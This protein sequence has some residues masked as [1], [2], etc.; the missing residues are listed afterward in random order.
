MCVCVCVCV[1]DFKSR[2]SKQ[3]DL[4]SC[5]IDATQFSYPF[6]CPCVRGGSYAL[7][8][9]NEE[10]DNIIFVSGTLSIEMDGEC[11]SS[12]QALSALCKELWSNHT[13]F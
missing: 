6:S 1:C 3:V 5:D 11:I 4:Y 8:N 10:T 2:F 9:V 12:L 13:I 7:G